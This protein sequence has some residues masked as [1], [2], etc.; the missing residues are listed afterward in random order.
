MYICVC[1]YRHVI[2]QCTTAK[3]ANI[4]T[5]VN[6][7]YAIDMSTLRVEPGFICGI[8]LQVLNVSQ[9]KSTDTGGDFF[10]SLESQE[11][12]A[13]RLSHWKVRMAGAYPQSAGA[14]RE[15]HTETQL[16][17]IRPH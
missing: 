4:C 13:L 1:A 11:S 7:T 2:A 3:Y 10:P 12:Q 16:H 14:Q 9:G 6:V 17:Q 5:G 15:G 8:I